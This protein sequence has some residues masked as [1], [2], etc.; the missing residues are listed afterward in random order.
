MSFDIPWTTNKNVSALH[1]FILHLKIQ[2]HLTTLG[3]RTKT[4]A[5]TPNRI[6][7]TTA[8]KTTEKWSVEI[9]PKNL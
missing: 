4:V 6:A 7:A 2:K 5:T 8:T 3:Q 9:F 1:D